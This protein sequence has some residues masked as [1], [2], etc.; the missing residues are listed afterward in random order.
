LAR[1]REAQIGE[2]GE[3]YIVRPKRGGAMGLI[4]ALA[5]VG[6]GVWAFDTV[7]GDSAPAKELSGAAPN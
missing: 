5:L 2:D 6:G 4:L 7:Y 3:V 1:I